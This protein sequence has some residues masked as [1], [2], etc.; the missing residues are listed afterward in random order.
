MDQINT[1]KSSNGL[2][3]SKPSKIQSDFDF[4]QNKYNDI[5]PFINQYNVDKYMEI[6]GNSIWSKLQSLWTKFKGYFVKFKAIILC[7]IKKTVTDNGKQ[8]IIKSVFGALDILTG[9]SSNLAALVMDWASL[10]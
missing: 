6:E 1:L 5:L 4:I 10:F 8:E 3:Y 7:F 9:I 2:D